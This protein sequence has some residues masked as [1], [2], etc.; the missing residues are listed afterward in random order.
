MPGMW[1][2]VLKNPWP[3]VEHNPSVQMGRLSFFAER[4]RHSPRFKMRN[5]EWCGRGKGRPC[6]K[7]AA[8][9][10]VV[11]S[12][13]PH[14]TRAWAAF[15]HACVRVCSPPPPPPLT[16]EYSS[17]FTTQLHYCYNH[18]TRRHSTKR[19]TAIRPQR[20]PPTGPLPPLS[21]LFVTSTKGIHS[22][23]GIRELSSPS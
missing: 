9:T 20:T 6:K 4:C 10:T 19:Q 23:Y 17:T 8:C 11:F 18:H 1:C 7:P 5:S 3:A 2:S 21:Q 13:N 14:P 16:A 15:V 22:I 12:D